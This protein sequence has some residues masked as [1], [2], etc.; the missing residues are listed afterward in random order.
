KVEA[1]FQLGMAASNLVRLRKL[2][3]AG[4]A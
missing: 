1:L 4:A 2:I 3:T